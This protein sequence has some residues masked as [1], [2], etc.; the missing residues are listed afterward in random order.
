MLDTVNAILAMD[1]TEF[2]NFLQQAFVKLY[3]ML[4]PFIL[5]AKA[6]EILGSNN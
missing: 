6:D 4:L 5:S 2:F 1:K 3:N